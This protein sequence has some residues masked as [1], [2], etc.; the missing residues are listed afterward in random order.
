MRIAHQPLCLLL[1][2][3]SKAYDK[4]F[5]GSSKCFKKCVAQPVQQQLKG[6]YDK[7]DITGCRSKLRII[8]MIR[9]HIIRTT[10]LVWGK[11]KLTAVLM[12]I[13]WTNACFPPTTDVYCY[14]QVWRRAK[15]SNHI[16]PI[17]IGKPYLSNPHRKNAK[18]GRPLTLPPLPPYT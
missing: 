3:S 8:H 4:Q 5:E 6:T 1:A 7:L 9:I 11:L 18:A 13:V 12:Y 17:R 2:K 10:M 15:R 16:F 14:F